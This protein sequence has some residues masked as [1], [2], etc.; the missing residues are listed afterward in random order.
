M[1][2]LKDVAVLAD[3]LEV[4]DEAEL[5]LDPDVTLDAEL[6]ELTELTELN[7]VWDDALDV[8]TS[9]LRL[10]DEL[11][12]DSSMSANILITSPAC[13]TK[14]PSTIIRLSVAPD[15]EAKVVRLPLK[16]ADN[17]Y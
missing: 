11:L 10:D 2:E 8:S 5:K 17:S 15:E 7:D 12:R 1:F 6:A 3:V 16:V 4:N 13:K 14:G 9:V